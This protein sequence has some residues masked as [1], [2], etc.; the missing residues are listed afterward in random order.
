MKLYI[1]SLLLCSVTAISNQYLQNEEW[2]TFKLK[3]GKRYSTSVEEQFRFEAFMENKDKIAAHN[4]RYG[5]GEV[6]FKQGLNK[7]SDMPH[8][9]FVRMMNI[10]GAVNQSFNEKKIKPK[11]IHHRAKNVTLPSEVDWR[12]EGAVTPVKDEGS[13]TSSYAFAAIGALEGRH[14]VETG[15]LV[16]LSEQNVI[17]CTWRF[18]NRGCCGGSPEISFHYVEINGGIDTEESYPYEDRDATC[19]YTS[20]H[21]SVAASGYVRINKYNELDLMSAVNEGPVAVKIDATHD[22]FSSYESGIY[23]EPACEKNNLSHSVLVVGY[24]SEDGED[25]WIVKN[26]FGVNWGEE[27]Y[28]RMAR[29]KRNNCGIATMACYPI[30]PRYFKRH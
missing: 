12:E 16:S 18:G 22:S 6:T 1:L 9:E 13:C 2:Q 5:K 8:Q 19:R 26:S 25:Y 23:Y 10:R 20:E 14:F 27:G 7:F 21:S 11:R 24:G 3:Y 17:D 28:I 4:A 15:E 30:I 29:N